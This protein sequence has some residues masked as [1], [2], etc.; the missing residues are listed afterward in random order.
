MKS[1]MKDT[2]LL[3]GGSK[4]ARTDLRSIFESIYYL[5]EAESA[6]KGAFLLK[7]NHPCIA[8][9]IAHTPET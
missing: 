2:L 4:K 3:I 9:V 6:E 5:L 1:R 8:A 7:H